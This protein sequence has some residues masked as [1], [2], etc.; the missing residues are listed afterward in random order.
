MERQSV[1]EFLRLVLI[2]FVIAFV[3]NI[4]RV[5][6]FASWDDA[7]RFENNTQPIQTHEEI[8]NERTQERNIDIKLNLENNIIEIP[9]SPLKEL[10]G[11]T[12]D[13]ILKLRIDAVKTSPIFS[14]DN[15]TPSEEVFKIDDGMPWISM[16]AALN[17]SKAT[18]KEKA[19][20]V[21]RDSVGILNPELLYYVSVSEGENADTHYVVLYKDFDFLPYKAEYN[22]KTKTITAHI[23]NDRKEHGRYQTISLAD[24]NAHDLGYKYAYMD[25]Y[26]NLGFWT[27]GQYKNNTLH[28]DI[29]EITGWYMHGPAC[30]LP[31][32]CNNY[33]P[34][35]QYYN[36]FYLDGLPASFNIKLW[37]NKPKSIKQDADINFRMVFE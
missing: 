23:K 20:G 17:W 8:R 28:S 21:S 27:E 31:G 3:I 10:S 19:N 26:E 16:N 5:L 13:E 14:N 4:F 36:N 29:K 7:P 18:D 9:M 11:L 35:W 15:Y 33:A 34:Y 1:L 32:G 6:I 30:G 37:K 2:A 25:N 12:K 22:P 24:T